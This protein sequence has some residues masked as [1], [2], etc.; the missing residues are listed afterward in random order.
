MSTYASSSR[1]PPT[2]GSTAASGAGSRYGDPVTAGDAPLYRLRHADIALRDEN[3]WQLIHDVEVLD[4]LMR[5]LPGV[6][7]RRHEIRVALEHAI[8]AVDPR[9]V[10]RTAAL[11]RTVLA[12]PLPAARPRLRT[13]AG[14]RRPRAHRLR[15]AVA[16]PRDRTQG[17]AHLQH[18]GH[19]HRGVP[20]TDRRRV[21]RTALRLD[22][23]APPARLRADTQGRRGRQLGAGRR[24][25]GGGRHRTAGRRGTG[26]AV[27]VRT[28]VLPGRVGRRR[29]RG[30]AARRLG[31][32]RRLPPA[33]RAPRAPAG[34]SA[35]AQPPE[36]MP[37][38]RTT[39]S[40]GKAST[41]PGCSP[42]SRPAG[43]K[44]RR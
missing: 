28:P 15:P 35:A 17:R 16:G 32:L 30:V 20:R 4:G 24:H 41:A 14:R 26:T 3:V 40:A 12:P 2:R 23:R 9:A 38:R 25:V 34:S 22:E 44:A 1:P 39:P 19:A 29:R 7:P 27:R 36:T 5:A 21:L 11:A 18:H 37:P 8:D 42:T 33:R 13:H 10:A 43:P 31:R 6:L